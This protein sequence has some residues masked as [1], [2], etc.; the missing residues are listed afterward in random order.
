[1]FQDFYDL[2][3]VNPD[4]DEKQLKKAYRLTIRDYHPDIN[5]SD[6]AE[7]KFK[8][9]RK[10][11]D[12][13]QD[14]DEKKKYDKLG[15]HKY[16]AA[17]MDED[18]IN[19]FEFAEPEPEPEPEPKKDVSKPHSTGIT[20]QKVKRARTT[21]RDRW[22]NK[23]ERTTTQRKAPPQQSSTRSHNARPGAK[24]ADIAFRPRV[25]RDL[26]VAVVGIALSTIIYMV[27]LHRYFSTYKTGLNQLFS[28]LNEDSNWLVSVQASIAEGRFGIAPPTD[29]IQQL[30][31]NPLGDPLGWAF[32]IGIVLLPLTLGIIVNRFGDTR[33]WWYVVGV[34]T[35]LFGMAFNLAGLPLTPHMEVVPYVIIPLVTSVVFFGDIMSHILSKFVYYYGEVYDIPKLRGKN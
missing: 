4:A 28:S 10:A 22:N 1:M 7:D 29:Y 18:L 5:D 35:P 6:D 31:D 12:I 23:T 26:L 27:G 16:V 14:E 9:A 25:R 2:F 11:F 24:T 30:I 33:T 34:L 21:P 19:V 32:P 20:T 13:L 15:H 8:A 3:G 17:Y